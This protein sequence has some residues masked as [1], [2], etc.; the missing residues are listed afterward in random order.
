VYFV[1]HA[2]DRADVGD[3]RVRTRPDHLDYLGRFDIVFGGPMFADD[4]RMCGSLIVLQ[5]DDRTAAESFASGDP[6]AK[7]GLFDQVTITAMKPVF[8][9]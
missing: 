9:L 7:T 8:G 6:Y 5:V 2:L 3:L 1:I 4:G